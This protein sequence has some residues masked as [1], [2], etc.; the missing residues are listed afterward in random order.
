MERIAFGN[1]L[2]EGVSFPS[3]VVGGAGLATGALV[4]VRVSA[5]AVASVVVAA[6]VRSLVRNLVVGHLQM[7]T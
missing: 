6:A 2:I 3:V 1:V 4:D 5:T 7:R